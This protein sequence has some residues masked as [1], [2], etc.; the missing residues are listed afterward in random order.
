MLEN[1]FTCLGG[2]HGQAILLDGE[3]LQELPTPGNECLE[4]LE[5]GVF[6]WPRS[7]KNGAMRSTRDGN[8]PSL[9]HGLGH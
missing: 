6:Y 9:G 5:I 2:C 4:R 3:H 8:M 1:I 7:L